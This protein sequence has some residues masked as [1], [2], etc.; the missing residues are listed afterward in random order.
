MTE[1]QEK[2]EPEPN[3]DDQKI[4]PSQAAAVLGKLGKTHGIN[5]FEKRGTVTLD[6]DKRSVYIQLRDQ[7]RSEPGRLEYRE[8]LAAQLAMM[9][10]LAFADMRKLAEQGR[11]IWTSPPVARMGVYTN[12]L[13]RL[14][15][16]WPKDQNRQTN[17]L[18][19]M[20]G[21]KQDD[22]TNE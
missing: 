19:I 4:T 15:D 5:A 12:A 10:D 7:F 9:L 1:K 21:A 6:A 14:I 2:Y 17:I 22:Q 8:Q 20:N 3:H 16:G 13:I 18:D 11:S